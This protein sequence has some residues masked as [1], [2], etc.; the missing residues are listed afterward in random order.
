MS[1]RL[2][3]FLSAGSFGFGICAVTLALL[4]AAHSFEQCRNLFVSNKSSFFGDLQTV[5]AGE[6]LPYRFDVVTDTKSLSTVLPGVKGE[7]RVISTVVAEAGHSLQNLSRLSDSEVLV[8]YVSEPNYYTSKPTTGSHSLK[9]LSTSADGTMSL[10]QSFDNTAKFKTKLRRVVDEDTFVAARYYNELNRASDAVLYR[11]SANGRFEI[12]GQLNN[13]EFGSV[14]PSTVDPREIFVAVRR[15]HVSK[16]DALFRFIPGKMAPE[17]VLRGEYSELRPGQEWTLKPNRIYRL[18]G[19][20]FGRGITASSSEHLREIE[21]FSPRKNGQMKSVGLIPSTKRDLRGYVRT[22]KEVDQNTF[23]VLDDHSFIDG[24]NGLPNPTGPF[25]R[26]M[27]L[28]IARVVD[29]QLSRQDL[30]INER[31]PIRDPKAVALKL[32]VLDSKQLLLVGRGYVQVVRAPVSK[33]AF[34]EVVRFPEFRE[35]PLKLEWI[36]VVPVSESRFIIQDM[37]AIKRN[38]DHEL[39]QFHIFDKVDGVFKHTGSRLLDGRRIGS[40]TVLPDGRLWVDVRKASS[41]STPNLQIID[42]NA[43][44]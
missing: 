22:S 41:A 28:T 4:P 39:S 16:E 17:L 2:G 1:L 20:I 12:A 24:D 10:V 7:A 44:Q 23:A 3:N 11:R 36:E 32:E 31:I 37:Y 13:V 33:F 26:E 43:G 25:Q 19:D 8:E 15:S 29:G 38:A 9:V 5:A 40:A 30:K 18:A 14:Y 42:L 35:A 21:V 6:T 34:A 27:D